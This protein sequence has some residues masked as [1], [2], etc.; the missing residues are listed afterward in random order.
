MSRPFG[1][2][3]S[4]VTTAS[5]ESNYMTV[6]EKWVYRK[7][8]GCRRASPSDACIMAHP[9]NGERRMRQRY[10]DFAGPNGSWHC[11]NATMPRDSLA[12]SSSGILP[13]GERLLSIS[14]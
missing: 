4:L 5:H 9:G 2:S 3:L 14:G 8:G 7:V 13:N 6:A 10:N 12:G 1:K 11:G